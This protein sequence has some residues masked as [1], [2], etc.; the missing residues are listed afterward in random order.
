MSKSYFCFVL[1]SLLAA[2]SSG[3]TAEEPRKAADPLPPGAVL[4]LGSTRLRPGGNVTLLAFSPDNTKLAS[5]SSTLYVSDA[6]CIWDVKTGRLLRRIDLPGAGMPALA[7]RP[8]G[9]GIALLRTDKGLL[10]WDFTDEKATPKIAPRMGTV[11]GKAAAPA[12]GPP[13]DNETDSCHA[14]SPDGKTLAIGRSGGRSDKLR[15]IRLRPLKSGIPVDELPAAKDLAQHPGNCGLL[16][17]T[18]NGKHLV[19]INAAREEDK[20]LVVV[21]DVAGGKEVVRFTAPHPARNNRDAVAVSDR[22]LA[23]GLEDGATSLWDLTNGKERRLDTQ[24]VGK[25]P[26]QGYGTFAVAFGPDGKT[27]VTGG[28]DGLVKLWD[29]AGG[30]CLH[31]LKRHYSWVETLAVSPDGRTVASAGQDGLIRLWDA[32]S[33]ADACPQSGHRFFLLGTAWSPEGKTILTSGADHTLHWWDAATGRERRVVESSGPLA[34]LVVSPDGKTVL[35]SVHEDGLHTWD[36][37]SGRETTPPGLSNEK[38]TVEM[39]VLAFTP[40]GRQLLVA[41]G[42]R[43]SVW[44]WPAMKRTRT[45]E[46]P[47]P[48][49]SPGENSC[50]SLAI[51]PD[52]RWLV[53]VALRSWFREEKGLRFGYAAEGVA[54]LWDLATGKRVRRLVDGQGTF[55]SATFTADGRLVLIG[56]GGTIPAEG[57]RKAH[58]FQGE[59]NLLDPLA[60]RWLRSLTPPPP[61]PGVQH[62]YTG[63]TVLSPDGRTLYVSYNTGAIVGFEVATGQPRRTLS[64]HRDYVAALECSPDGRRLLSGGKDG[65]ALVWDVTLAGAAKPRKESLGAD[66][67][68]KL[69]TAATGAD[70]RDA[71]AALADL[72]A[73]PDQAL[74]LLRRQIKPASKGPTDAELD[75]LFKQL[76]SDDFAL[77]EKASRQ[78][79]AFGESAVPGVRKRLS[80]GVSPEVR[81][82]ARTFLDQFDRGEL[83]PIRLRQVRAIELLEGIATP[84]AKKLLS[85]LANGAAGTPLT[86]EAAAALARLGH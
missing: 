41:S 63:A 73:A 24:H 29:V 38:K 7:W 67:V 27:L 54:D 32:A 66:D 39:P 45:I 19:A 37:T 23:I 10:V 11:V 76:D 14:I 35:A 49:K 15:P 83:S 60:A 57:G 3:L 74:D 78:L 85:E 81:Q 12:G 64:G 44:D 43:V 62:R 58:E 9:H 17:F 20:Q 4:R 50:R 51:S 65:T 8:D 2:V 5:W 34:G 61:T 18:P 1:T 40:N 53:T 42:P 71:F 84:A 36:L 68:E 13:A 46:L 47:K 31:T 70:S 59:M 55:R 72:A 48:A 30:R 77:R 22:M 69:W 16:L 28:R 86:L 80:Q 21:W 75:R 56:G 79:A 82:R 33:G 52:S 25:K 26:G 6:L